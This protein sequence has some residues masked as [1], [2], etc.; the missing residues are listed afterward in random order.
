MGSMILGITHLYIMNKKPVDDKI[1]GFS[2]GFVTRAFCTG[3]ITQSCNFCRILYS[4]FFIGSNAT[5]RIGRPHHF[6]KSEGTYNFIG[7]LFCI[8]KK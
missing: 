7:L 6:E 2:H 5:F 8:A 1:N 4:E 3:D